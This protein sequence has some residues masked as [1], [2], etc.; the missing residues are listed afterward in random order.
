MLID[1]KRGAHLMLSIA[2]LDKLCEHPLQRI[3]LSATIEPLDLA[4]AGQDGL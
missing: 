3:G 2:R 4:A 1:T